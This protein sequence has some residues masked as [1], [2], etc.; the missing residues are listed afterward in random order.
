MGYVI[1][2]RLQILFLFSDYKPSHSIMAAV[3]CLLFMVLSSWGQRLNVSDNYAY[4]GGS[5]IILKTTPGSS[6]GE[7]SI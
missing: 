2:H 4:N 6:P 5:Y 3:R 1:H 7:S